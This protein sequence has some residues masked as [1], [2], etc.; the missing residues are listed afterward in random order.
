MGEDAGG[1]SFTVV[2]WNIPGSA[3]LDV[4]GVAEI[5]AAAEPD[6]VVVQEIQRG[7]ARR[8]GR[9]LQMPSMR[10]AF[11]NLSWPRREG[12]AVYTRHR[13]ATSTSFVLRNAWFWN[14]RRRIALQAAIDCDGRLVDIVNVH[15][16]PH[17][18]REH[19]RREAHIVIE[20][21]RGLASRPIIAGDCNDLPGQPGPAEFVTAG[22]VDA[23]M[24]D[25]LRDLDGST[26]WTP[27][28]RLGRPPTQRL[29]YVFAPPDWTVLDAAVLATADRF[30]WFADR[31]D[32][33]P[34][35]ATLRPPEPIAHP[36]GVS[37]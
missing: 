2:T 5:V 32:H 23:W 14:W 12:L 11:K 19:R 9:A 37:T 28:A 15:L 33:V 31:S 20:R 3:G 34:L 30:D 16:S 35:S 1:R 29:D 10:W 7:Q 26:N 8:L 27:G 21:V 13:I 22:W 17:D 18:H 25:Q 24:L 36:K 6:V 4:A